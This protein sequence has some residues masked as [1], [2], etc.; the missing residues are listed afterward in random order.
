MSPQE[1]RE[2]A[3]NYLTVACNVPEDDLFFPED[4]DLPE[5]E[6]G[7]WVKVEVFIAKADLEE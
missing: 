5:T 3:K 4:D 1:L 7:Y 6:T 2:I